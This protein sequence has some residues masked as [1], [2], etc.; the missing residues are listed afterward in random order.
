MDVQKLKHINKINMPHTF[1]MALRTRYALC[2]CIC[3]GG[4]EGDGGRLIV[5]PPPV[6][7]V[8]VLSTDEGYLSRLCVRV[9]MAYCSC[10]WPC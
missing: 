9:E 1:K 5:N 10:G 2:V 6:L 8:V 4:T 7:S 3:V